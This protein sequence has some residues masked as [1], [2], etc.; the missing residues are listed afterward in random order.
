MQIEPMR[1]GITTRVTQANTYEE[2]RDS[3]AHDWSRFLNTALPTAAWLAL[4]NIGRNHILTYCT[5]W[6]INRLI[7]SGGDDIG[8]STIRDETETTLLT[9]AAEMH[10][11]VLGICRGMQLMGIK[12][13]STLKPVT[14]HVTTEHQL[15]GKIAG[16]ANSF[17]TFSLS[18]CPDNYN[19]TA[20]SEDGEIE[21]IRH[22]HLPWEGW[23]WHPERE[24]IF[25]ERDI[26]NIVK[27][28]T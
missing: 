1:I 9:W 8:T 7:L 12:S 11:P 2:E 25:Q 20:R 6:G 10:I 19:I 17:H 14:N 15:H 18:V 21:A 4:P 28:F 16:K 23:M 24:C 13:G 26:H 22:Q 5:N 3:L 27:L